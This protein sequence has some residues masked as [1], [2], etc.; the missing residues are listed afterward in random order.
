M[1]GLEFLEQLVDSMSE[2]LD[3]LEKAKER[4][5][6]VQAKKAKDFLIKLQHEVDKEL[7]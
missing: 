5:N 4:G 6:A 1:R 2:G 7:K 3:A